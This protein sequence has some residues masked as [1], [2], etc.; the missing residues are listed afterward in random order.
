MTVTTMAQALN[1]ALRDALHDDDSVVVFGEDVGT[2][3]V[4]SGSPMVLPKP[5]APTGV[6][7]LRWQNRESSGSRWVWRWGLS[8]GGRDAIRRLRLSRV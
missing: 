3:G 8:P 4:S 7:I 5:S 2:L 1:A 6:S